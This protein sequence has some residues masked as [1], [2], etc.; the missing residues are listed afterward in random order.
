MELFSRREPRFEFTA[1]S[2]QTGSQR[3]RLT[4]S[5]GSAV[6]AVLAM[7]GGVQTAGAATYSWATTTAGASNWN[8]AGNWTGGLPVSDASTVLN[9][10]HAAAGAQT[11]TNNLGTF[12]LTALNL[13]TSAAALTLA[14]NQLNFNGT[15]NTIALSGASHIVNNAINFTNGLTVTTGSFV[16]VTLGG[17][18]TGSGGLVKNGSTTTL[19]INGNNSYAGGTQL[20]GST[21]SVGHNNALGSG[22]VLLNAGT[23]TNGAS[24]TL[25]NAFQIGGDVSLSSSS[26]VLTLSNTVNLLGQARTLNIGAGGTLAL[27]GVVSNGGIVKEGRGVMTLAGA[28]TYAGGTTVNNGVVQFATDGAIPSTGMVTVN[29]GGALAVNLTSGRTTVTSWLTSGKLATAST[30]TIALRVNSSEAIN[31]NTGSFDGLFLGA[32]ADLTYTGTFT[33]AGTTYRLGGGSGTS[34]ATLTLSNTNAVSGSNTLQVGPAL[35]PGSVGTNLIAAQTGSGGIVAFSGANSLSGDTTVNSGTL[36]L[37]GPAG[38]LAS[39]DITV[40]PNG[41]LAIDTATGTPAASVTRA[42]SVALRRGVM[43]VTG[44]SAGNSNDVITGSINAASGLNTITLTAN[45]ATNTNLAAASLDRE[46]G[47]VVLV[48]GVNFGLNAI[49][50]AATPNVVL[51]TAPTF[52]GSTD[53]SGTTI[54]M[55]PWAIGD[56]AANGNGS[57]FLTYDSANGLRRLMGL[58][59]ATTVT[60]GSATLDNAKITTAVTGINSATSLNSL[61][62]GTGGSVAGTG[63]LSIASGG[64]LSSGAT[65]GIH[66]ATAG[67]LAFGGNEAIITPISGSTL[68]IGS[69]ITGSGGLSKNGAGSLVLSGLNSTYTGV[70]TIN[71]GGISVAKLANG[72]AT[73]SIGQSSN[74]ASNLVLDGGSLTYTG[75][76][77]TS[78]RLFSIG[79]NGGTIFASGSGGITLNNTGAIGLIGSGPRVLTLSGQGTAAHTN[80]LAAVIGDNGG[81]TSVLKAVN[82]FNFATVWTL[83]GINTYTGSTSILGDTNN[84]GGVL[85]VSTL[86]DGGVASNIGAS[87]SAASNLVINRG[88]LMY[89]G[90]AVSTD[91]LFTIG[92]QNTGSAIDASG[93]GALNFTNTGSIEFT[94]PGVRTITLTGSN[95]GANTMAPLIPDSG[96]TTAAHATGLSKSGAGTWLLTNANTYTG[97]TTITAGTLGAN[98]IGSV[99]SPS[100][101]ALG[102]PTT[103]ANGTIS[104]GSAAAATL[105]YTG[106]AVTT[107]RVINLA[108]TTFGATIDASGSGAINFSSDLTATGNGLKTLTLTG[109]N[110]GDNTLGGA[111][112]NSTS[113]TAV[114]KSG[115][116][117]WV[118]AG[119]SNYGGATSVT[120]GLL[121]VD[122]TITSAVT[123][124]GGT[125]GG[126]GTVGAVTVQTAGTI[127]A[128]ASTGLLSTGALIVNGTL[129]AEVN[130]PN[131]GVAVNGY[132]QVSVT[133]S[134]TLGAASNLQFTLGYTPSP[135]DAYVLI[136][137]DETD[138]LADSS[139]FA[140]VNGVAVLPGDQFAYDFGGDSY[141]FQ[142]NYAGGTDG[143]DVVVSQVPEPSLMATAL[144][145]SLLLLPRRRRQTIR[146]KSFNS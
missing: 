114:T 61:V 100:A 123:V 62:L 105:L 113:N 26:Q 13:T 131:A 96:A 43:T 119:T 16:S 129:F 121:Q 27:N 84:L 116:G 80:T 69:T 40:G 72:G 126:N 71:T 41:T 59:Y 87:T 55:I 29:D 130:G 95:T 115:V 10:T 138:T 108:G 101:S 9:F 6:A 112:V 33:P 136:A 5:I 97:A 73:S 11:L 60:N 140:T 82:G 103:V 141:L 120:A 117:K 56:N 39:S 135:S 107:D 4:A 110:T 57:D 109:S 3:R 8:V 89:T 2:R 65:T 125:L 134:V 98:S 53:T 106:P 81:P 35:R 21:V 93:S 19:T 30:G 20:N 139:K 14:G 94:G 64:I 90:G 52:V 23:L 44:T 47:A 22:T 144:F 91:R 28:N 128:G 46:A 79:T 137:N 83:S 76:A 1:I 17:T 58:E 77:V 25:P 127:A 50:T 133:G 143:N 24:R 18:I 66:T 85:R 86:A 111:I 38:G 15:S 7:H 104:I 32:F 142:I 88:T 42:D 51:D 34:T 74:A 70:T 132:D 78:D 45:A 118:L 92:S 67:T 12:N 146:S 99:A 63:A 145:S 122:G 36:R 48:R 54:R 124:S 102:A 75:G 31:F 68:T 37:T 49:G